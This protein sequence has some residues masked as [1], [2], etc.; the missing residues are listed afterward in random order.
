MDVIGHC[1]NLDD[2]LGGGRGVRWSP[3]Q[4]GR[5]GQGHFW[6]G[7]VGGELPRFN[8][9]L[10]FLNFLN[11]KVIPSQGEADMDPHS[12]ALT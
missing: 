5:G 6:R 1:A 11:S 4:S 3:L 7:K 10:D 8:V 2:N 9:S 12:W